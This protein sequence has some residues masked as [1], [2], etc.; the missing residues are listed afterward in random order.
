MN[1]KKGDYVK[2]IDTKN[3]TL[4]L[5]Q[6]YRVED[7]YDPMIDE[8]HLTISSLSLPRM[9]YPFKSCTRFIKAPNPGINISRGSHVVYIGEP[10][11]RLFAGNKY[12]VIKTEFDPTFGTTLLTLDDIDPNTIYAAADFVAVPGEFSTWTQGAPGWIPTDDISI[13]SY[14]MTDL[15]SIIWRGDDMSINTTVDDTDQHL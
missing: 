15:E 1:F 9:I 14:A 12:V 3:S 6:M 4:E 11:P 7:T 5:W 8:Q 10:T 2:C 13:T